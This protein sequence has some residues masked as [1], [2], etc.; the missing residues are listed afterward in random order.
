MT[1]TKGGPVHVAVDGQCDDLRPADK[2]QYVKWR[3][4]SGGCHD[5]FE[6]ML[7]PGQLNLTRCSSRSSQISFIIEKSPMH[8]S[9]IVARRRWPQAG[10]EGR[11]PAGHHDNPRFYS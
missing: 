7:G 4:S 2:P 10:P 11:Y 3:L 6:F 8:A 9:Q 1:L 5:E